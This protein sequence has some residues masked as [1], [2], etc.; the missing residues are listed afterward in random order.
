[1]AL[2]AWHTRTLNV[3]SGSSMA[4]RLDELT[5]LTWCLSSSTPFHEKPTPVDFNLTHRRSSRQT[6]NLPTGNHKPDI[7]FWTCPFWLM[8]SLLIR[9]S[10]RRIF[11]PIRKEK[12]RDIWAK[13]IL[14]KAIK[15]ACWTLQNPH[16]L[17]LYTVKCSIKHFQL[18]LI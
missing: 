17:M 15:S 11:Q 18:L 6:R 12:Q 10:H 4:P 9:Q 8:W 16:A 7:T 2:C 1:M 3:Q 13:A 14:A 5:K